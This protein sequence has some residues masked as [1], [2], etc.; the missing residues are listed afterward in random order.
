MDRSSVECPEDGEGASLVCAECGL[1]SSPDAAGWRDYLD[2]D[3][4]AV[5]LFGHLSGTYNVRMKAATEPEPETVSIT[6]VAGNILTVVMEDLG[7]GWIA[8]A[9]IAMNEHYP[10]SGHGE[11]VHT[12][13]NGNVLFGSWDIQ[14]MDA[15]TILVHT[16]YS[17]LR[18]LSQE[19]IPYCGSAPPW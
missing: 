12:L 13:R 3:G 19:V 2:D 17:S 11:Y 9:E 8:E 6:K 10:R 4:Q 5:R 15:D 18:S 7:K 14:L 16:T 1:E